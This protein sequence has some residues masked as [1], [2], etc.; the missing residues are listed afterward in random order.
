VRRPREAATIAWASACLRRLCRTAGRASAV[1]SEGCDGGGPSWHDAPHTSSTAQRAPPGTRHR[2]GQGA[3]SREPRASTPPLPPAR[4]PGPTGARALSSSS[5]RTTRRRRTRCPRTGGSQAWTT[6]RRTRRGATPAPAGHGPD[7]EGCAG[8]VAGARRA[9]AAT[10]RGAAA[11]TRP[12]HRAVMLPRQPPRGAACRHR[13]ATSGQ[14]P[15]GTTADDRPAHAVVVG[16]PERVA[17]PH[18]ARAAGDAA[19]HVRAAGRRRGKE[20]RRRARRVAGA[21][22]YRR[23]GQAVPSAAAGAASAD[24]ATSSEGAAAPP[25]L[26]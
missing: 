19:P 4:P 7:D 9:G 23:R 16:P 21:Q 24:M 3:R 2:H 1:W 12:G 14:P 26:A 6:R 20:A 18:G 11:L 5:C 15:R 8:G 10:R 25:H 13:A 17:R 22:Q